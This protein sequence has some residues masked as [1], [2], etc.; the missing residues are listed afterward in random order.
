VTTVREYQDTI[1]REFRHWPN[2]K[3]EFSRNRRHQKLVV[4]FN[5]K[6]SVIIFPTSGSDWRGIPNAVSEV[7]RKLRDMGAIRQKNANDN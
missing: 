1:E 4:R 2:A 3:F 6:V 5:C 7:R